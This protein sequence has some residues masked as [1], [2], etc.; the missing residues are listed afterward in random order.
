MTTRISEMALFVSRWVELSILGKATIMLVLGLTAAWLAGRGRASVRHLFL[1]ATFGMLLALPLIILTTPGITIDVPVSRTI[2]P[3]V[4]ESALPTAGLL[5]PRATASGQQPENGRWSL[6]SWPQIVRLGWVGGT[7]IL[8]LSLA[9]ALWRLRRIRRDGLP[10]PELRELTQSL[11][12]ECGIQRSIEV[13][14]HEDILAPL[15]CGVWR[16]AIILPTEARNWSDAHLR[17][18]LIHELEHVRRCDWPIQLVARATCA[19]YWFH[20]LV[21]VACRR[22]GLEAER[23][24]D[25]AVVQNSECAD[26][27]EQ[28]VL[29]A[30]QMSNAHARPALGMANRSD[31]ST[32]ITAILDGSQRR[33]RVGLAAAAIAMG[34]ATI[35]VLTIAPVRAVSRANISSQQSPSNTTP[36]SRRVSATDRALFEAAASGDV[37]SIEQL[38]NA[39]ANVNC[40]LD[41]DGSPLIGAARNG[42]IAAVRLLLDRGADPNLSVRGDGNPLIMAAREG[43]ADVVALL[44]DRGASID[45]MVPDDENALIQASGSGQLAVVSLLVKRGAD[46][47]ARVWVEGA[48]ESKGEWRSPLSMARKG[49]HNGVVDFLLSAGAR[50][51]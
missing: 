42:H 6:P 13:L 25:D 35:L 41:G 27:A 43:H 30:R 14:L 45:Q 48:G 36:A 44:L 3:T 1:V 37:S 24:C 17:R 28:L 20:P 32:R 33:G 15:T 4:A 49:R 12:T 16:P 34:A 21:W 47:N 8:F 31:L 10:W 19:C 23:A 50:E 29:L 26:Y 9:A 11:A 40:A 2:G 39:G 22:L 5:A 46:V 18:A 7:V 38:L 51:N